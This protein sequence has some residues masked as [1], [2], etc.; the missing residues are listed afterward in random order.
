VLEKEGPEHVILMSSDAGG[1][2]HP[3]T[4]AH[5]EWYSKNVHPVVMLQAR[6]SDL[7]GIGTRD[8][9]TGER[10]RSLGEDSLLTFA[11]LAYVKG[12]FPSKKAQFC[13]EYLKLA[14]QLRA[15]QELYLQ[16]HDVVR[17]AGVRAD[18]SQDRAKLSG[19]QHDDYFDCELRRPILA[20]TKQQCFAFCM[21]RG[22]RVNE[23]YSH[24]FSRVGCAPCVNSGK[25]DVRLWAARFPEMIDKVRDWEKRVGRT[26]F[27]P[28]IPRPEH[29]RAVREWRDRWLEVTHSP[30]EDVD[31]VVRVKPGAPPRPATPINWIDEVVAWSKT[32]RGGTQMDL[33]VVEIEAEA[34]T[35]SSKYGLCE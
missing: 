19:C 13:T 5:V 25:D 23:L 12:R 27:P 8:G 33:P 14:P 21:G 3:M 22:E 6:V 30:D 29:N 9:A 11:D 15:L 32:T 24:G 31:P 7:G 18:E 2:E 26:F 35:C 17:Y 20:W 1:N 34:G 28:C 4:T 16:G 10:R